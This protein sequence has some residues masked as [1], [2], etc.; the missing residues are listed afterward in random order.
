MKIDYIGIEAC[1]PGNELLAPIHQ[2]VESLTFHQE[3][4]AEAA[5]VVASGWGRPDASWGN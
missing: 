1:L 4:A 2:K 3:K 5:G